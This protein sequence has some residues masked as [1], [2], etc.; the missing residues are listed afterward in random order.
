MFAAAS[1]S[2][3]TS[4]FF[5]TLIGMSP[6]ST[7]CSPGAQLSPASG[8]VDAGTVVVDSAVVAS[9]ARRRGHGGLGDCRGQGAA[10]RN[11]DHGAR[12]GELVRAPPLVEGDEL[13]DRDAELVGNLERVVTTLDR[14]VLRG[15]GNGAVD[16]GGRL[17]CDRWSTAIQILR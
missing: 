1:A 5:A 6:A 14:V 9:A 16:D 12:E 15:G 3:V 2:S 4:Y 7:M 17:R 11:L 8:I 13:V 10:R